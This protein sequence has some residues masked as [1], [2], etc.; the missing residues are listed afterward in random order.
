LKFTFFL[1]LFSNKIK[2]KNKFFY[3]NF[4]KNAPFRRVIEEEVDQ[5]LMNK[6]GKNAFSHKV[7][8]TD[9]WEKRAKI[10]E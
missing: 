1:K 6:M 3:L 8:I 2:N 10:R 7:S 5:E 9:K 4:F